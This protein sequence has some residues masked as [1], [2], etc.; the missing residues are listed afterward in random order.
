MLKSR[1]WMSLATGILFLVAA[2]VVF[3][4]PL[5][6]SAVL[7]WMFSAAILVDGIIG[8]ADYAATEREL[9][10]GWNLALAVITLLLGISLLGDT[11]IEQAALIPVIF[12][13]WL[14]SVGIMRIVLGFTGARLLGTGPTALLLISGTALALLG[15]LVV[16]NPW[17]TGA[18]LSFMFAGSLCAFGIFRIVE[19]FTARKPGAGSR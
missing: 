16:A 14:I 17:F 7:G 15:C 18:V 10:S 3:A 11:M 8:I 2:A 9:R 12:G 6:N 1:T 13:I 5:L 4:N 19:F